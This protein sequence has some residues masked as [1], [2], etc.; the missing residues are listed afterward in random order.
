MKEAIAVGSQLCDAS[1]AIR[2]RRTGGPSEHLQLRDFCVE[3]DDAG[4]FAFHVLL[5]RLSVPLPQAAPRSVAPQLNYSDLRFRRPL[6]RF[7]GAQFDDTNYR[8]R[9][10]HCAFLQ[11]NVSWLLSTEPRLRGMSRR[12]VLYD[13][14]AG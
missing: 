2:R 6:Q 8:L 12:P 13:R 14:V 10:T 7:R 4:R 5:R 11:R 9:S 3:V 1:L